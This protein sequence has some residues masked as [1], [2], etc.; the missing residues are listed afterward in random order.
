MPAKKAA[1][2]VQ[3]VPDI[4]GWIR[5]DHPSPE[6]G[7]I[8]GWLPEEGKGRV[9]VVCAH[10]NPAVHPPNNGVYCVT[11]DGRRADRT[12]TQV[13]R[14]MLLQECE[15]QFAA[16]KLH[17]DVTLVLFD[18]PFPPTFARYPVVDATVR[19][20][21]HN[22]DRFSELRT[23]KLDPTYSSATLP[24]LFGHTHD[25]NRFLGGDSGTP[26]FVRTGNRW[27]VASH[28]SRGMWGEG[29]RY[30]HP[31]VWPKIQRGIQELLKS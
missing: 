19:S 24:W 25:V 12:I 18:K 2:K 31:T 10:S 4:S 11:R 17:G 3:D 9:G 6:N 28:T 15:D 27:G 7:W 13:L 29:P 21:I 16:D 23:F 5:S 20:V 8:K 26:W 22:Y 14:V 1:K 30:A